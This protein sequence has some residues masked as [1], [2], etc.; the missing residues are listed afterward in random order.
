LSKSCET[1]DRRRS[2]DMHC[3]ISLIQSLTMTKSKY[4]EE[5]AVL[6]YTPVEGHIVKF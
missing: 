4:I 6:S 2:A 5:S 1:R 3:T